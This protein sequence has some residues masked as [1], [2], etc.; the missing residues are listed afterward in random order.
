MNILNANINNISSI[1]NIFNE[2]KKYIK[3]QGFDQWQ[4]DDYPNEAILKR[5][6][7]KDS[8]YILCDNDKI[9][10]YMALLLDIE[11]TYSTIS[12]GKWE[13]DFDYATIHRVALS[14]EYRGKKLSNL[15]FD[16]AEKLCIQ[17]NI[18]SLRVD[19]HEQNIPMKKM[20]KKR[21]YKHCGIITLENNEKRIAYEKLVIP[22][23]IGDKI[24][25]RKNH[26]CGNN[27]FEIKRI[28]MDFR[29]ECDGCHSQIWLS[30][31]DVEKRLK[32]R[33]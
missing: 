21:K 23:I 31:N 20:L 25:M 29:L 11:P 13:S 17:K 14:D 24:Q 3:S 32:K 10:G 30:R 7:T 8:G 27:I 18:R 26:P 4:N 6:I 22:F 5:D 2:A 9:I 16:F 19:T 12:S 28:G 1:L 33:I 15:L